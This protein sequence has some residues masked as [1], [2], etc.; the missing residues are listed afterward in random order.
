MFMGS[1]AP[2]RGILGAFLVLVEALSPKIRTTCS[3][4]CCL[5]ALFC[6]ASKILGLKRGGTLPILSID[7][8]TYM[9]KLYT[10][11]VYNVYIYII[12]VHTRIYVEH[13]SFFIWL[14]MYSFIHWPCA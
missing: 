12:Y 8:Q 11:Y 14:L 3:L 13:I 6:L 4:G 5:R 9:K 2:I 1:F 7:T 10:Y